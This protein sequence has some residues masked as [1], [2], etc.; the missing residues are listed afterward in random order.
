MLKIFFLEFTALLRFEL[1]PQNGSKGSIVSK[2]KIPLIIRSKTKLREEFRKHLCDVRTEIND[3]IRTEYQDWMNDKVK[4]TNKFIKP[5]KIETIGTLMHQKD[6]A[7]NK[8]KAEG[9][10][11]K[12]LLT[13]FTKEKLFTFTVV[14]PEDHLTQVHSSSSSAR[15][16]R[17]TTTLGN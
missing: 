9:L 8:K 3:A 1:P 14:S 12:T 5:W 6:C 2:N 17:L 15:V 13:I 4:I 7:K 11:E 10:K 16:S